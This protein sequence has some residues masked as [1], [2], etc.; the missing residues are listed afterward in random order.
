MKVF[1][2]KSDVNNFSWFKPDV[3][4][5]ELFD[6]TMFDCTSRASEWKP[7]KIKDL[8]PDHQRG[9]FVY[10]SP[11]ALLIRPEVV[12]LVRPFFDRAGELLPLWF[13]GDIY[14]LLN[15]TNCVDATDETNTEWLLA[16]DGSKVEI[17]RHA[18]DPARLNEISLFKVP[19]TCKGSV[20]TW[21]KDGTP[22]LEF[23]AFVEQNNLTG[24]LFEELWDS[25]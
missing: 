14:T 15:I 10:Y 21:E 3:P 19:E 16:K 24:L 6:F 22:E 18:F 9:D 5:S 13:E 4:E 7:P 25:E 2:V 11:G 23:K 8:S 1:L 12:H 20:L 17:R